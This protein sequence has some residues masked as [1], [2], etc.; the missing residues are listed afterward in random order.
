VATRKKRAAAPA[1]A[2][3]LGPG[4]VDRT[5]PPPGGEGPRPRR[6][7]KKTFERFEPRAGEASHTSRRVDRHLI[8][9]LPDDLPLEPLP[10]DE[11]E[12]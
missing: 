7:S 3:D 8:A 6:M 11:G 12:P 10:N 4:W 2:G 5:P 1:T 9:E